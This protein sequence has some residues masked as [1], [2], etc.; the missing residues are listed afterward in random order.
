MNKQPQ[1]KAVVVSPTL[2]RV[3]LWVLGLAWVTQSIFTIYQLW[4]IG[5]TSLG[6]RLFQ[7]SYIIH[8]LLFF[9]VALLAVGKQYSQVLQRW[10]AAGV[11][12]VMGFAGF[13]AV[14]L[15]VEAFR[16]RFNWL[17]PDMTSKSIL[18][19]FWFEWAMMLAGLV[20]FAAVLLFFYRKSSNKRRLA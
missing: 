4:Y 5:Y 9:V 17:M 2:A 14:S 20:V 11:L 3:F 6:T 12:A 1:T 15:V 16:N 19:A 13:Q 18:N 8:P 10:F 7:I